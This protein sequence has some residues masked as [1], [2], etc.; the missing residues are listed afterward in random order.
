MADINN[1]TDE[2]LDNA[3]ADLVNASAKEQADEIRNEAQ[4]SL[5]IENS[6]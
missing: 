3:A 1:E 5:N 4:D 6:G 2:L